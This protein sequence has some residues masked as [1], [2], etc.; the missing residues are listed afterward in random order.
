M[1]KIFNENA[2]TILEIDASSAA[3]GAVLS[4]IDPQTKKKHPVAFF[5]K[6]M[7]LKRKFQG[8]YDLELT[9]LVESIIHFRQ[10]LYGIKF[11][12]LTDNQDLTHFKKTKEPSAR[13][14]RLITK[15]SDFDFTIRHI[16]G[17]K[18]IV[19]DTLSRTDIKYEVNQIQADSSG[20]QLDLKVE[21]NNDKF[22]SGLIGALK[23]TLDDQKNLNTRKI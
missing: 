7:P 3:I 10:Y 8:S 22:C 19:P 6:K 11:E 5:S 13:L 9:G 2:K 12:V 4:Q 16:P 20:N 15:L 21:Q 14:A 17:K 18:N 1:L 23:N